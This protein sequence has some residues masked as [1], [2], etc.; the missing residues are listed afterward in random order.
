M[1][2]RRASN[3]FQGQ[4]LGLS[5]CVILLDEFNIDNIEMQPRAR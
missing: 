2:S 5:F 3:C 1:V 4:L